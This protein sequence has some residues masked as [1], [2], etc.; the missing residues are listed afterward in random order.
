MNSSF[1]LEEWGEGL[2]GMP[3]QVMWSA[4][5]SEEW[6]QEGHRVA[7]ALPQ[8]SFV[9]HTGGRWAQ[10]RSRFV[11]ACFFVFLLSWRDCLIRLKW[12]V[13]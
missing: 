2:K 3:M 12:M 4:G 1:G 8:A 13:E 6:S 11:I 5:W 9:T 10:V 7:D